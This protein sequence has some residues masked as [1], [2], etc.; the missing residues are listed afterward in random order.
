MNVMRGKT[1]SGSSPLLAFRVTGMSAE[2]WMRSLD[3]KASAKINSLELEHQ[4]YKGN[5]PSFFS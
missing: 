1:G 5:S 2:L 4:E 3:L